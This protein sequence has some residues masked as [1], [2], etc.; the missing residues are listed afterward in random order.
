MYI[1]YIY[2]YIFIFIAALKYCTLNNGAFYNLG[3]I[4]ASEI[5]Q[6]LSELGMSVSKKDAQ[7]I[8]QRYL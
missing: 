7:K 6:S 2:I 4:D 3:R 8:L 1:L 5:Q